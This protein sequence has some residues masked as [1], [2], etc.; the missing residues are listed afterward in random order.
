MIIADVLS[1]CGSRH[2]SPSASVAC[3]VE[4]GPGTPPRYMH[5]VSTVSIAN[6]KIQKVTNCRKLL[7]QILGN[8]SL[9]TCTDTNQQL[10]KTANPE[11]LSLR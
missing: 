7:Q 3:V 11:S 10:K 2:C 4:G 8:S 9:G 1:C 6:E 5:V